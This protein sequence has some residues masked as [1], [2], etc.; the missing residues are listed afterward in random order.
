MCHMG[1]CL[2]DTRFTN[3][4]QPFHWRVRKSSRC[5]PFSSSFTMACL[6]TVAST[7]LIMDHLRLLSPLG[8]ISVLSQLQEQ[9]HRLVSGSPAT[10]QRA[11]YLLSR[12]SLLHRPN[13][14]FIFVFAFCL[15][16]ID[17]LRA[18]RHIR[19]CICICILYARYTAATHS[20]PRSLW[21]SPDGSSLQLWACFLTLQHSHQ[22]TALPMQTQPSQAIYQITTWI[23][24]SSTVLGSVCFGKSLLM[25]KSWWV[26]L[27]PLIVEATCQTWSPSL[28]E[29]F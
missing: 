17:E 5:N 25:P 22:P 23:L 4:F 11:K 18:T 19:F 2:A 1:D 9:V 15:F 6:K 12:R 14:T 27:R 20:W 7:A 13:S 10:D 29:R 28:N 8:K 26:S 24:R 16:L 21:F 3:D